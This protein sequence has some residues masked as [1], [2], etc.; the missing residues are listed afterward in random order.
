MKSKL[1]VA[2]IA[3][4]IV[5]CVGL[6]AWYL[7]NSNIA[8]L[9]PAG[10]IAEKERNLMYVTVILAMIIIVPVYFLTFFIAW[11]YREGKG[12]GQYRPEL[13]GNTKA[14][15]V[16]WGIPTIIIIVLSVITWN[17]S[18]TLDPH[19]R[20]ESSQKPLI[21]QVVALEWKWLFMYPEEDIAS[22]NF[23][24]LPKDRPVEFHI[25]ADAP[26]NAFW[27]PQ[28]GSQI[29]A[30]PGMSTK[31]N[32]IANKSG[33]YKGLSANISGKGFADM[34]FTARVSEENG[35]KNWV[36]STTR[37]PRTL[38]TGEYAALERPATSSTIAYADVEQG[39]YNRII[40]K[41]MHPEGH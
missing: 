6:L 36:T 19:R 20:I 31:L 39:L 32:L 13:E 4:A 27:I 28:L 30:M 10:A 33:D 37:A 35:Y 21:V 29:Y 5:Y 7:G 15:A 8:V 3:S 14:E 34:H 17:S 16:W 26:M 25:T 23:L 38:S 40:M 2:L 1:R 22:V 11:R 41:Y 24:H 9:N 12:K 18:H